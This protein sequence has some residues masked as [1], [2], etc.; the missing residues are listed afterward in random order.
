MLGRRPS[1]SVELGHRRRAVTPIHPD[2]ACLHPATSSV[3]PI[4]RRSPKTHPAPT[5]A[6]STEPMR[7]RCVTWT[8]RGDAEPMDAFTS[9]AATFS[10]SGVL[11]VV[12][13]AWGANYYA[14]SGGTMFMTLDRDIF[15]P[16]DPDNLLAAWHACEA[17][18]FSLF[19][20]AGPLDLPRDIALAHA[21]VGRRA[22]TRAS[23][24]R[25]TG[26][27]SNACCPTKI[28]TPELRTLI[29]SRVCAHPWG[30]ASPYDRI[31]RPDQG[32]R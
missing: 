27:R 2:Q 4:W 22:L 11:Y 17:S 31:A 24:E 8:R 1:T 14:P 30:G 5:R 13:G 15:L 26:R 19:A 6:G 9:L 32:R 18:R 20:G 3:S 21:V 16:A 12:I 29:R 23:D 10:N 7:M 28:R 25:G